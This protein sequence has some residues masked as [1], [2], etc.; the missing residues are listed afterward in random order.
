MKSKE[1]KRFNFKRVL[2]IKLSCSDASVYV[3]LG[4]KPLYDSRYVTMATFGVNKTSVYFN[5][6]ATCNESIYT[7]KQS[8][9]IQFKKN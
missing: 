3:E 6:K 9:V 2:N 7:F 4:R 8:I 5:S 1:I